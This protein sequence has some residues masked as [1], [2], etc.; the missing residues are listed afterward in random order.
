MQEIYKNIEP[1]NL[2]LT[3]TNTAGEKLTIGSDHLKLHPDFI[4][5]DARWMAATWLTEEGEKLLESHMQIK[6]VVHDAQFLIFDGGI[7]EG[8]FYDGGSFQVEH[9][10]DND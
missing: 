4:M 5:S 8:D 3:F 2:R 1:E 7:M 10:W 6:D 9:V